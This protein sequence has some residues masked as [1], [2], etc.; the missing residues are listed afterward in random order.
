[1]TDAPN[2]TPADSKAEYLKAQK[3]RN[4]YIALAL[5]VFIALVFFISMSRMAA[6]LRRD[7]DARALSH[8]PTAAPAS[9]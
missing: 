4:L 3:K 5:V 8:T 1:M 7:A 2:P 9:R 6:G